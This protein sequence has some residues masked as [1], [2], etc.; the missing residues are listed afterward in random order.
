[1]LQPQSF[2]TKTQTS[3]CWLLTPVILAIQEAAIR[4]ITVQSQPEKIFGETLSQNNPIQNRTG[5]VAQSVGLSSNPN[6]AKKKKRRRRKR[7]IPY[8]CLPPAT[9]QT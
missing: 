4:R 9:F 2:K 8:S 6:T 1:V 7:I 5:E 3:E